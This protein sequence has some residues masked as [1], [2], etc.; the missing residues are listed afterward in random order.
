MLAAIAASLGAD[1]AIIVEDGRGLLAFEIAG[2]TGH[3]R[4]ILSLDNNGDTDPAN[5]GDG[6]DK[7]FGYWGDDV[8]RGGHDDDRL[9]GGAGDDTF[10]FGD[11]GSADTVRDFGDGKDV[12]HFIGF[13]DLAFDDLFLSQ[14]ESTAVIKAGSAV[15]EACPRFFRFDP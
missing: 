4:A 3:R 12:I 5:G 11:D 7:I 1:N 9:T 14:D 6:E 10:G 13:D 8:L 15:I 2:R